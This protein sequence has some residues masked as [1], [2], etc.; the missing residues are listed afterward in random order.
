MTVAPTARL[1]AARAAIEANLDQVRGPA[2]R[3]ALVCTHKPSPKGRSISVA[4]LKMDLPFHN[5]LACNRKS[6]NPLVQV[7]LRGIGHDGDGT[8][9]KPDGPLAG[10]GR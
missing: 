3:C 4:R 1:R 6:A 10:T 9:A 5:R 7:F 2:L 8:L